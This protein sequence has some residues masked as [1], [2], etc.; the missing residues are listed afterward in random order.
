MQLHAPMRLCLL[1]VSLCLSAIPVCAQSLLSNPSY[2]ATLT[3]PPQPLNTSSPSFFYPTNIV[4]TAV[5]WNYHD[6][7]LGPVNTW[8][9][10]VSQ[11]I[12]TNIN[13]PVS[14]LLPPVNTGVGVY[15]YGNG[16]S[17]LANMA[18]LTTCSNFS[19][20]CVVANQ[21]MFQNAQVYGNLDG[22]TGI[23]FNATSYAPAN[24]LDGYWGA[25]NLWVNY[26]FGQVI[27]QLGEVPAVTNGPLWNDIVDSQGAIYLNGAPTSGNIG[28][29]SGNV[30]WQIM[31]A[32]TAYNNLYGYIKYLLIC[33]NHA[34]TAAEA[35]QLYSWEQTNGMTN[36]TGSLVGWWKFNDSTSGS[37]LAD[38]SGNGLTGTLEGS[39]QPLWTNGLNA[40]VS[41]ALSFDGVQNDVLIPFSL[42]SFTNVHQITLS[43]WIEY[44]NA[45]QSA[46]FFVNNPDG[47]F[48]DGVVTFTDV[49]VPVVRGALGGE[50]GFIE[51]NPIILNDGNWH[52]FVW[53]SDGTNIF[54]WYDGIQ[55]TLGTPSINPGLDTSGWW[56]GW[57]SFQ[58]S[59]PNIQDY[60]QCAVTDVRLYNRVLSSS[61]VD[62]LYRSPAVNLIRGKYC[63]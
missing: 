16:G 21:Y 9:D 13:N 31:G 44:T 40:V 8:T 14:G 36:V 59:G 2:V 22:S 41:Q 63:Y 49:G 57:T 6:L 26:P 37:V 38:S 56:S 10:E 47:A 24:L 58:M 55:D 12:L 62:M 39:P 5:F 53:A 60:M 17:G 18:T 34:I 52:H 25:D 20:W 28:E 3:P 19:L 54:S 23:M 48:F 43:M 46:S 32:N 61:E 15:F 11:L 27:L 29:P 42:G 33:T 35:S 51:S 45:T 7:P 30:C 4:N 50:N 1:I